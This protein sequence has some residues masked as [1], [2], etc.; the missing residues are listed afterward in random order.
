M[1]FTNILFHSIKIQPITFLSGRIRQT[2]SKKSM[3]VKICGKLAKCAYI[4]TTIFKNGC[5]SV[6]FVAQEWWFCYAS[7]N[8]VKSLLRQPF[9]GWS[10]EM[11]II[12]PV[13]YSGQNL[14]WKN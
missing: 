7:S 6:L 4:C 5:L 14:P 10:V 13:Q 2:D 9:G 3:F 1:N 8:K 12:L 11:G